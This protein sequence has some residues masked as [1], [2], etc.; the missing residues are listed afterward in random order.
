VELARE[1]EKMRCDSE[2]GTSARAQKNA[3][4]R[5]RTRKNP[6]PRSRMDAISLSFAPIL[7]SFTVDFFFI[8]LIIYLIKN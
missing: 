7:A 8:Y 5:E 3:R 2:C 1:C 4:G 6:L